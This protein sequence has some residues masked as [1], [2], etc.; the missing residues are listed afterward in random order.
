VLVKE[1]RRA[2]GTGLEELFLTLTSGHQR[3]LTDSTAL[4]GALT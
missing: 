4:E 2:D 1:L 3:D